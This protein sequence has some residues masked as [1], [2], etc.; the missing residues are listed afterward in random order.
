MLQTH[1]LKGGVDSQLSI[2]EQELNDLFFEK[3]LLIDYAL[4]SWIK[5]FWQ[6][7]GLQ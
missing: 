7:Q 3:I 4:G 1:M 5:W 2:T 6:S